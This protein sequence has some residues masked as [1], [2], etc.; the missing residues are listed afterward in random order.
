MSKKKVENPFVRDFANRSRKRLSR[1]QE[2][3][4]DIAE[5]NSFPNS[6]TCDE[7]EYREISPE[8]L[9][10]SFRN[11][12]HEAEKF[13]CDCRDSITVQ[14]FFT[15]NNEE[16]V[17]A[18]IANACECK[19]GY[20]SKDWFVFELPML[21]PKRKDVHEK[22][23]IKGII[24]ASLREYF[25]SHE[26][27]NIIYDYVFCAVTTY[28]SEIKKDFQ[29]DNDNLLISV[30]INSFSR[31]VSGDDNP[32]EMDLFVTS[33][34]GNKNVTTFYVVP[35]CDFVEWLDLKNTGKLDTISY[36]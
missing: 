19:L 4:N 35:R 29:R 9:K 14:D 11:C 31:N 8:L 21:L 25:R 5:W 26:K 1:L 2:Y 18:E 30:V 17:D 23:Y 22:V 12:V 6:Y 15:D 24:D 33:E 10:K 36:S 13:A 20:T 27:K 16:F 28:K 7:Y 34:E 3:I 32:F